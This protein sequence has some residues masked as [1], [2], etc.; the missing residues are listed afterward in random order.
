MVLRKIWNQHDAPECDNT[1]ACWLLER[2]NLARDTCVR[3]TPVQY[4]TC[5][6]RIT[7]DD[8]VTVDA[9]GPRA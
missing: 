3:T 1:T 4:R 7:Y 2:T 8:E 9:S 5:V 6:L